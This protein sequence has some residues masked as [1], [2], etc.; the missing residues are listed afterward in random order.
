MAQVQQ[1]R[2]FSANSAFSQL[3]EQGPLGNPSMALSMG[4]SMVEM[5]QSELA[6]SFLLGQETQQEDPKTFIHCSTPL[7]EGH[8][9]PRTQRAHK[10]L[11]SAQADEAKDVWRS[12]ECSSL[13]DKGSKIRP[14]ASFPIP[15]SYPRVLSMRTLGRSCPSFGAP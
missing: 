14:S 13:P 6:L 8:A 2:D 15:L 7:P 10:A 12:L 9:M 1:G 4:Q 11:I 5:H 3:V